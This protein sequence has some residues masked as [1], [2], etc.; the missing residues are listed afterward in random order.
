MVSLQKILILAKKYDRKVVT[1]GKNYA[2]LLE[3]TKKFV[4]LMIR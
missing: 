4:Y 3:I 1:Y 2:D